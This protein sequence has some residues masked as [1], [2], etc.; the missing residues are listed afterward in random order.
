MFEPTI[1]PAIIPQSLEHLCELVGTLNGIASEIQVDIVDD[2]VLADRMPHGLSYEFDVMIAH[3]LKR[4]PQWLAKNPKGVVLHLEYFT[5]TADV[6]GAIKMTHNAAV[7]AILASLNDTPIERL[8]SLVP[9]VDGIQCMG[10]AEIG[11]QGNP[12][13]ARVLAR[14]RTIRKMHPNLSISVDGSVNAETI[15]SLKA[16]GANR[17]VVGSAIFNSNDPVGAYKELCGLMMA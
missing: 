16:A 6:L 7:H 9:Q 2:A 10:I 15:L 3:P 11:R 5:D 13:D 14:I 17:F 1:I 8:L 4:L 12:F